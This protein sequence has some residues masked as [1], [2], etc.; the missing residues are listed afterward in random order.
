MLPYARGREDDVSDNPFYV[1]SDLM[2]LWTVQVEPF[3]T[4]RAVFVRYFLCMACVSG[5]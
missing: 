4:G 5:R 3:R 1:R 2:E